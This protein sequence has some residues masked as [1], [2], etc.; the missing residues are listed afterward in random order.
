MEPNSPSRVGCDTLFVFGSEEQADPVSCMFV[1]LISSLTLNTLA[2][3]NHCLVNKVMVESAAAKVKSIFIYPIKSCRGI[4]VSEA[5]LFSTGFRWDRQWVV[6]NSKRRACTQRVDPKLALVEVELPQDAFAVGWKPN[7]GSHLESEIASLLANGKVP[8]GV[9]SNTKIRNC[10]I[11]K[12][13]KI[14]SD[15]QNKYAGDS[16]EDLL[17]LA[18]QTYQQILGKLL[19]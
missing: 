18:A 10:T 13:A 7:K 5:P 2:N 11:D 19:A 14:G 1:D 4:S 16:Y 6:V 3:K 9:R 12:N 8:I 17:V 15:D